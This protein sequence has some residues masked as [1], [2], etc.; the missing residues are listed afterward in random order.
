M[1]PDHVE[2]SRLQPGAQDGTTQLYKGSGSRLRIERLLGEST[3]C[4][5]CRAL[6]AAVTSVDSAMESWTRPICTCLSYVVGD[7]C[8][9]IREPRQRTECIAALAPCNCDSVTSCL[10]PQDLVLLISSYL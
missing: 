10:L 5:I 4:S 7:N 8:G 1:Q 9:G 2:I 6:D 3:K